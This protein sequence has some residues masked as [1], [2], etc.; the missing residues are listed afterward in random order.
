MTYEGMKPLRP[1]VHAALALW[2]RRGGGLL[3]VN[4][5]RDPYNTVRAWWNDPG[6]GMACR[7]PGSIYWK[8]WG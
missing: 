2:V 1:E 7:A 5:D 3:F 4:D 8:P 6:E